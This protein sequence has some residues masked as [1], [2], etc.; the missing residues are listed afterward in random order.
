[1]VAGSLFDLESSEG[2]VERAFGAEQRRLVVF[3]VIFGLVGISESRYFLVWVFGAALTGGI[4][5]FEDVG[6]AKKLLLGSRA[7]V[8]FR[9]IRRNALLLH[10]IC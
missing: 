2:E 10:A 5:L 4:P 9:T 7:L 3:C 1:L 8:R 6:I